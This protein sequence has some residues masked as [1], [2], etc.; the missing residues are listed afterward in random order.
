MAVVVVV[1][2]VGGERLPVVV[3]PVAVMEVCPLSKGLCWIETYHNGVDFGQGIAFPAYN[4]A[5]TAVL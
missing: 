5:S 3:W 4:D 2:V 1:V